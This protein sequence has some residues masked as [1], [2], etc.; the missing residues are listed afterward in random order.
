MPTVTLHP[1]KISITNEKIQRQR[2]FQLSSCRA[3]YHT[4]ASTHKT[5]SRDSRR[6][7]FERL[8]LL[9]LFECRAFTFVVNES[10]SERR[11][12]SKDVTR[13]SSSAV[14]LSWDEISLLV[15]KFCDF[16][17]KFSEFFINF[18]NKSKTF[19]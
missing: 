16:H 5:L 1:V 11:N 12:W 7:N 17:W 13:Q 15:R 9:L 10:E 18:S 19:N 6:F 4:C 8:F 2:H 14:F 3:G